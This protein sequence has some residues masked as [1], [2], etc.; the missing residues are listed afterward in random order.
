MKDNNRETSKTGGTRSPFF[1][2]RFQSLSPTD[3]EVTLEGGQRRSKIE[4]KGIENRASMNP[5]VNPLTLKVDPQVNVEM[6]P[7]M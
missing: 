2:G 6:E 7:Q 3:L 5:A 4:P 1:L